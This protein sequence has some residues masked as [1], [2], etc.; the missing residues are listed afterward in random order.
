MCWTEMPRPVAGMPMKPARVVPG[1]GDPGDD[2]VVLGDDVVDGEVQIGKR[3]LKPRDGLSHP[4]GSARAV[5]SGLVV[6][7]LRVDELLD[8]VDVTAIEQDVHRLDD[9]QFRVGAHHVHR[10]SAGGNMRPAKPGAYCRPSRTRGRRAR[11]CAPVRRGNRGGLGHRAPLSRSGWTRGIVRRRGVRPRRGAPELAPVI[12]VL[13]EREEELALIEGLCTD[14][15]SGH[16][17][18]VVLEG[19]AGIGKTALLGAA[20][21]QRP[22]PDWRSLPA[23]ETSSSV[24]SRSGSAPAARAG[25]APLPARERNE[26]LGGAASLVAPLLTGSQATL[27]APEDDYAALHG[28]YWACANLAERWPLALLVTGAAGPLHALHPNQ[29]VEKMDVYCRSNARRRGWRCPGAQTGD[30]ES[31]FAAACNQG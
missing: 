23:V 5:A 28:L 26:V 4:L 6:E 12:V 17:R 14:A 21:E 19:P 9:A 24:T 11:A 29:S 2:L 16:G 1:H 20:R 18:L 31:R 10:R 13:R 27:A 8:R 3:R 7:E 25:A 30:L 22:R 15:R